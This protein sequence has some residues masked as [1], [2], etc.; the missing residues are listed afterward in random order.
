M[1]VHSHNRSLRG[2]ADN[3]ELNESK[4]IGIE[5]SPSEIEDTGL[6][7]YLIQKDNDE[8]YPLS[9]IYRDAGAFKV[10]PNRSTVL[11][12]LKPISSTEGI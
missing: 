11:N 7:L 8:E 3:L 2:D 6:L 5:L 4:H 1:V 9:T 10:K 12:V